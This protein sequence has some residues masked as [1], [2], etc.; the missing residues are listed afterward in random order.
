MF[1]DP[2]NPPCFTEARKIETAKIWE[3]CQQAYDAHP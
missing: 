2:R 3:W 1:T